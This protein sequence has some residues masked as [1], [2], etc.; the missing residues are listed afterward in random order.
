MSGE[1]P[2]MVQVPLTPDEGA[3]SQR[4][5]VFNCRRRSSTLYPCT[6]FEPREAHDLYTGNWR[7][8]GVLA[9][10]YLAHM[11]TPTTLGPP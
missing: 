7:G 9:Q 5:T 8:A 1:H 4:F 6:G 10:G 2:A 11:K 3:N